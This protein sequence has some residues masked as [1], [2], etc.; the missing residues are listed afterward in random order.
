MTSKLIT[1]SRESNY[2]NLIL[3]ISWF[4]SVNA[5]IIMKDSKILIENSLQEEKIREV[6]DLKLIFC[7]KHNLLMYFKSALAADKARANAAY[8]KSNSES[9]SSSD[10]EN[11]LFEVENFKSFFQ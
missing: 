1:L 2:L 11:D 6:T 5:I 8:V 9:S 10:S 7:K 3:N 4:W